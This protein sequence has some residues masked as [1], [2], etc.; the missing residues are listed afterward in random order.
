MSR[1]QPARSTLARDRLPA[2]ADAGAAG[3]GTAARP[4]PGPVVDL[5]GAEVDTGAVEAAVDAAAAVVRRGGPLALACH[6]HPDGDALG[7]LLA[8]KH[9]CEANGVPTVCSWP[10]PFV[11]GPHYQFLPGL[12]DAVAPAAFPGSPDVMFTFDLGSFGRLGNLEAAA[13]RAG[14]LVVLDH[15]P[16]NQRFGTV[17]VVDTAAAATAVV[18]RQLA[19]V[20]GWDLTRD[21]AVCL[22]AGLVT[23]TGR[24]R[25]PNT[26]A[27]VFHFAEELA[28]WDIP[29]A[30]IEWE[31]FEKHRFDYLRL[32]GAVLDRA[33]LDADAAL[34]TAWCT[35]EDLD[36]FGVQFDE[37]EGLIDIV[38]QAAEAEVSCVL[39]EA[40]G[41][42]VRVS[43]RSTGDLDVG[44][45]ARGFGGGGHWFMSGFQ[46]RS[47]L[48]DVRA[49]VEAA[50][51]DA[52]AAGQ[53]RG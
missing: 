44:A 37:T 32:I 17:N 29:I 46:A 47:P 28:G 12:A 40:P 3:P 14:T 10:D 50:V 35:L 26:T 6:V 31:L 4:A 52:Q 21:A 7:S 41:E 15:H 20:L 19:T 48:G 53:H 25:Y 38:R 49:A 16:D 11:T 43:L 45:V 33:R 1:P 18:V 51:R 8:M 42:G 9:L 5:S 30:R 27:R 34:V 24:F 36:R 22:Y 2:R 39:R 13:R 23:D